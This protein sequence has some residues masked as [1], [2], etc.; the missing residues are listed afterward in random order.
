MIL[1]F[2]VSMFPDDS[3]YGDGVVPL[4]T[5]CTWSVYDPYV[6]CLNTWSIYDPYVLLS[7]CFQMTP[8]IVMELFHSLPGIPGVY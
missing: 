3:S 2:P 6:P 1:L 5:W 8:L 7:L 4:I